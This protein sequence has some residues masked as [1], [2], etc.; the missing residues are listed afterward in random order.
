VAGRISRR[1]LARHA[2]EQ[3]LSGAR[4]ETVIKEVAA[5]LIENRRTKEAD[6]IVDDITRYL[7]DHGVVVAEATSAFGLA[8][9]TKQAIRSLIE[10]ETGAK[11]VELKESVD[12]SV[13]GGVKLALPGRELDTTIARKLSQL[14]AK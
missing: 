1:L 12:K 3:L 7:A 2:G 5:Y 8:E 6:L 14:R 11:N 4:Q 13:L 10:R 9:A